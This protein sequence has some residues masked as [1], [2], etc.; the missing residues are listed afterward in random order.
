MREE[1]CTLFDANYLPRGLALYRS[2]ER[3]CERFRLRVFCMDDA[4]K[5]ILDRLALPHLVPIAIGEL[6][7]R[8]R[9]LATVKPGRSEV[10]YCWTA[11]PATCVHV[12]ETEPDVEMITYIDADVMLFSD[13]A[14]IFEEMGDAS[15]VITPHRYAPEYELDDMGPGT[16][17]ESGGIYN[18]QWVTFRRDERG[19]QAAR[20]WRE[21]CIEW[22]FNRVEDGR[23]G[24]QK[25]LDDWPQ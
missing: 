25:Y 7:A 1:F 3:H 19:L 14:P 11:T 4:T 10:E 18:V 15:I 2:L 5:A 23:F 12:L 22:C 16:S 8:D 6:E 20:W 13:P 9:V 24:D 17:A 21:R